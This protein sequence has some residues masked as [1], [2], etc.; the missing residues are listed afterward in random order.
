MTIERKIFQNKQLA[1]SS[2]T[3]EG[4][5]KAAGLP[6]AALVETVKRYNH[7]VEQGQDKDFQRFG[8]NK[9]YMARRVLVPPFYAVQFFP[10]T[11]KSMGGISI[12]LSCH[13]LDK[14]HIIPGLY[15]V[16]EASGF[17]GL[18]GKAGLEGTFLGPSIVT[19]R[20]A[21]RAVLRDLHIGRH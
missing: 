11:R 19:G 20:V 6:P 4:L 21:A 7:M 16:G 9:N 17:G 3:I 15:A 1:K 18:N 14:Q 8:P 12:D 2:K 13:V 5:A 10:V